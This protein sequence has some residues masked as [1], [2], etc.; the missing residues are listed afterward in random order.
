MANT[1]AGANLAEIAEES[2]PALQSC[3]AP[4]SALTTDFSADV[5]N[6]GE[7]ITTRYP[8]KPTSADMSGGIKTAAADVAMTAATV[9][10]SNWKGFT[11]GFDDA[12]RSKS[13]INL[14]NLFIEPAL[15]AVGDDVFGAVWNLIV[16]ANFSTNSVIT[17]ANFDRDDLVDLKTSLT[18]TLKA[19]K[20]GRA[21]FCNSSY[22]GA[23]VKTL[24]SAE[25]PGIGE[26]KREGMVPR[27]AGFDIHETD[28]ADANGENLA[29]FAFQR[30][31]LLFAGRQVDTEMAAQAGVE[32]ETV[33]IPGLGLPVQFRRFYDNDGKLYYNMNILYGVAKGTGFGHRVLSA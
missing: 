30:T 13:A 25:V 14:N 19:P 11:Y 22:H 16:N 1:I 32:V 7:S 20:T 9:T 26:D 8:T 4:L 3:F 6:R 27:S 21:V 29:A 18:D 33:V 28:L 2:L 15:Q 23:L 5:Q 17:A 12:E 10:L 31:A 24:N